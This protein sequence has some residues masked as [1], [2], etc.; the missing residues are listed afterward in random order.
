MFGQRYWWTEM[1]FN[2]PLEA[3]SLYTQKLD[4]QNV[5][6]FPLILSK[7]YNI[8]NNIEKCLLETNNHMY[9]KSH[10][11][12]VRCHSFCNGKYLCDARRC[13]WQSQR[14]LCAYKWINIVLLWRLLLLI[15][16]PFLKWTEKSKFEKNIRS[17]SIVKIVSIATVVIYYTINEWANW[18]KS[19]WR[20]TRLRIKGWGAYSM[21]IVY[22]W[23][24]SGEG[25]LFSSMDLKSNL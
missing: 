3:F 22:A 17:H 20:K 21:Y 16:M 19:G 1:K 18:K 5:L 24:K 23:I 15:Q 6:D 14:L 10:V 7:S 8:S 2:D 11:C 13:L 4:F 9:C 25:R 12:K